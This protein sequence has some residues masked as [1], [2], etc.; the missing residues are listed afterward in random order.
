MSASELP[1]RQTALA[2][3]EQGRIAIVKGRECRVELAGGRD[4]NDLTPT[5]LTQTLVSPCGVCFAPNNHVVITDSGDH[6]IKVYSL[7]GVAQLVARMIC[8]KQDGNPKIETATVAEPFSASSSGEPLIPFSVTA[9][10]SPLSQ[11]FTVFENCILVITFDW[12]TVEVL[13]YK[14]LP[15]SAECF[16][17]HSKA[18]KECNKTSIV[19]D[20]KDNHKVGGL[21]PLAITKA[22]FC[23]MFYHVTERQSDKM[24]YKCLQRRR[25]RV[26]NTPWT[27]QKTDYAASVVLYVRIT[28]ATDQ[29][30]FHARYG[31]CCDGE[32]R[33]A[34]HAEYF[35]LMDEEFRRAVKIL[36]D[37][38][39]GNIIVFMNKQPCFRSTRH[40]KGKKSA[41]L[42]R[43]ECAKDLVNFYELH[44][45]SH[46]INFIINLCQ[47]YKVDKHPSSCNRKDIQNA[48]HGMQMM[49]TAGIKLKAMSEESWTQLATYAGIELPKYK[50][51][52][53]GKLDRHI[54]KWI[55]RMS[56]G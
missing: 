3:S 8:Y 2:V 50:G 4:G 31:N 1:V 11:L 34:I 10:P 56:I 55:H 17:V 15:V 26:G 41:G 23:A 21:N 13:D 5:I 22:Q 53:R 45:S 12:N 20:H 35:M 24:H 19:H 28:D 43:K 16:S 51:S 52:E 49:I 47:L 32:R 29:L 25:C 30:I 39:G 54:D 6:S 38:R 7:N 9:G 46:S 44:C 14:K 40:H 48:K 33:S 42:K 37:Q 27:C 36:S 18:N